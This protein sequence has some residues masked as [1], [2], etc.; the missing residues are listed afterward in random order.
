[1]TDYEAFGFLLVMH[2]LRRQFEVFSTHQG[3]PLESEMNQF[4]DWDFRQSHIAPLRKY[5]KWEKYFKFD[6]ERKAKVS[7]QADILCLEYGVLITVL[8]TLLDC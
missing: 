5:G 1:M 3:V 8:P 4:L 7:R 2:E 6:N